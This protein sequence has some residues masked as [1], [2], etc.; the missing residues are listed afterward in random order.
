M[1]E[2]NLEKNEVS[3]TN[4]TS[5][6]NEAQKNALLPV[7]IILAGLFVGSLFVDVAQMFSGS[8]FSQKALSEASVIESG[9]RSWVAYDEPVVNVT[10]YSS[11]DCEN[12]A[13]EEVLAWLRRMI[14]TLGA[15]EADI[16]SVEGQ[17]L[18]DAGTI[19][20]IPAFVFDKNIE[21]TT[22]YTQAQQVFVDVSDNMKLLDT[23]ALGVPAGKYLALPEVG[24]DAIV[25]GSVDAPI[26][27][28]EYSD[29]QCPYCK[30]FHEETVK[31]MLAEYG[32]Q[33]RFIYKHLPLVSIHPRA[34]ISALAS[35][36]ANEQGEFLPYADLL[37]ENQEKW[38][39]GEGVTDFVSYARQLRLNT[40]EFSACMEENRY[41]DRIAADSAE[42]SRFGA[43]GT[44]AFFLNDQ[45]NSGLV[46]F[47]QLKVQIE[48]ELANAQ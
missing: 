31:P 15:T 12:C 27:M 47:E 36:C 40:Q 48:G 45:F 35:E 26:T 14:P 34:T 9:G 44:P 18:V 2:K 29:F 8:G 16:E 1:S 5:N 46:P 19:Q 11:S 3:E 17:K 4:D 32:D 28:I 23:A 41:A 38:G 21:E 37:F 42:A 25:V 20:A 24:E 43:S 30:A 6:E 39:Q 22:F 33:V 10:V 13:P 7:A